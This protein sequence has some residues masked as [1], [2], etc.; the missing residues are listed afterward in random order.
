MATL[1]ALS[2]ALRRTMFHW[3]VKLNVSRPA[4]RSLRL[5]GEKILKMKSRKYHFNYPGSGWD[6]GGGGRGVALL[7][8]DTVGR[9]RWQV[10][11]VRGMEAIASALSGVRKLY[12]RLLD[13]RPRYGEQRFDYPC[14]ISPWPCIWR[15]LLLRCFF[16]IYND[17]F[18]PLSCWSLVLYR[19][20]L[21]A[22]GISPCFLFFFSVLKA[23]SNRENQCR[24]LTSNRHFRSTILILLSFFLFDRVS[25]L[26]LVNLWRS[27]FHKVC[28]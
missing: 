11:E 16:V 10:N 27:F 28:P 6:E 20:S 8:L 21:G 22:K 15:F 17:I 24:N 3:K 4:A 25:I 2:A 18:N 12:G 5:L 14:R 9:V 1:L 26:V 13:T 23:N 7:E 19:A